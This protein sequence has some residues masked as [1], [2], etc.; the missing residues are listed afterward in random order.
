MKEYLSLMSFLVFIYS[1][2]YSGDI[3]K[4]LLKVGDLEKKDK[5][6]DRGCLGERVQTLC[7]FC[8][9]FGTH[10]L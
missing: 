3:V 7:L 1:V 8:I 5:N 10:N 2:F 6:G 9:C 4:K